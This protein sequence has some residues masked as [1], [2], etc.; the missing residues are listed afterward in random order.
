MNF[1]VKR[2]KEFQ[3]HF[4]MDMWIFTS[5]HLSVQHHVFL[6]LQDASKSN[7]DVILLKIIP[8][9][10]EGEKKRQLSQ[11]RR[12]VWKDTDEDDNRLELKRASHLLTEGQGANIIRAK[13]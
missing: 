12:K 2:S 7:F 10:P 6:L 1:T 11:K 9:E 3:Q 13:H 8:L 4:S 5:S